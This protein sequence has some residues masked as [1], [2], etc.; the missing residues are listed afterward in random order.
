MNSLPFMPN[1]NN[2]SSVSSG[3]GGQSPA[4]PYYPISTC[5][6]SPSASAPATSG[7]ASPL[8]GINNLFANPFACGFLCFS[9][10]TLVTT[11]NGQRKRLDQLELN[12]WILSSGENVRIG[13][14]KV[15]SWI[16]RKPKV[17]AEFIKFILSDG[18][19]L[20]ITNKHFIYRGNC[21][22]KF[23]IIN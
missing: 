6:A 5:S 11:L 23:F 14:S 18:K 9:G 4:Y 19:E 7:S 22:R 13:Y 10:D 16:H 2:P 8:D 1:N 21:S 20:K 17:E 3:S 15:N 12:E